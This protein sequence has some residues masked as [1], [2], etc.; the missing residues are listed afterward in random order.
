MGTPSQVAGVNRHFL[1]VRTASASRSGSHTAHQLN[2]TYRPVGLDDA[3]QANDPFRPSAHRIRRVHRFRED[4]G[5]G[6]NDAGRIRFDRV[7]E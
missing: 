4:D 3:L 5:S 7:G 2:G 6:L 1:T